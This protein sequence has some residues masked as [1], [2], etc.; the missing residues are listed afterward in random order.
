MKKITIGRNPANDIIINN[1][2]VSSNHALIIIED[3]GEIILRDLNSTNGTFVNGK[4]IKETRISPLDKIQVC[5][6]E[7]NWQNYIKKQPSPLPQP[8]Q[9][10]NSFTIGRNSSNHIVIQQSDVSSYHATIDKTA[11]GEIFIQDNNS[12][13]GTYVNGRKISR[14]QLNGGDRILLASKYPVEW[15][16]LYKKKVGKEVENTKTNVWIPLIG[17]VIVLAL[18]ILFYN[19]VSNLVN[20]KIFS[21]K[22]DV[23]DKYKNS[24]VLVYHSFV[25]EVK[26]GNKI[27]YLTKEGEEGFETYEK[28][29]TEPI[30]ITGTGF[31]VSNSG[32]IITNRHVAVPWEYTED[33]EKLEQSI[34][35]SV[36]QNAQFA[37]QA[38][39]FKIFEL[40]KNIKISGKSIAIGIALNNSYITSL[41]DFIPCVLSKEAGNSEID[42]AMLQT[43]TKSLPAL[44]INI[45][46]LNEA[47]NDESKINIGEQLF[48]I[49]YPAGFELATTKKGI[50]ANFQ[51]GQITRLGDGVNFGHN[52]PTIGGG[53]GSPI[54]NSQGNLVGINYKG[55]VQTQG[56]NMAMLAKYAVELQNR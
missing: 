40:L 9:N 33:K 3:S 32:E 34:K 15:E 1:L 10:P 47:V 5:D 12:S 51:N 17:I 38:D 36:T 56:F 20:D 4:K 28:G 25:Y 41:S 14:H 46:N 19:P 31:F 27:V 29:K 6:S 24:V 18:G 37:S 54:F 43:K 21:A 13:N 26:I 23:N 53:S 8:I 50:M 42:V 30:Q 45:V 16:S 52:V 35:E 49:G 44:V 48:M 55:L 22:I 2:N 7:I 39:Q 11:S